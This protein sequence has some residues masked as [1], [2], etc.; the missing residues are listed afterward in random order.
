MGKTTQNPGMG[1][2]QPQVRYAA[3]SPANPGTTQAAAPIR[4][5]NLQPSPTTGPVVSPSQCGTTAQPQL[6][7]SPSFGKLGPPSPDSPQRAQRAMIRVPTL[8]AFRSRQQASDL[9][10]QGRTAAPFRGYVLQAG[11]RHSPSAAPAGL[12]EVQCEVIKPG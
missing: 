7:C 8:E 2:C 11:E 6:Q 4:R 9:Q 3:P 12:Q 1:H 5:D 10:N